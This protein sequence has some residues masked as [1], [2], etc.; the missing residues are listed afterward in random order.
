MEKTLGGFYHHM[1]K[2]ITG[3]LFH[4][5]ADRSWHFPLLVEA[6]RTEKLEDLE[7]YLARR[8]NTVAQYINNRRILDLCLEV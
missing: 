5:R 4:K 8:W 1:A 7:I 2:Q 3:N 6:M